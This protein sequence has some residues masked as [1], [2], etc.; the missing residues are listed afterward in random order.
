LAKDDCSAL[1][2]E[3]RHHR[4]H[5]HVRPS[6]AGAEHPESRQKDH[7]VAEHIIAR[8]DP[9][10]AHVGIPAPI[11]PKQSEGGCVGKQRR[12]ADRP[13]RERMR[14][15]AMQRMPDRDGDHPEAKREHGSP[16]GERG[17][18]AVAQRQTDHEQADRIVRGIPEEIER[19]GLQRGRA[20]RKT[21]SDL[22]REHES[23][24]D[25][26]RP[27]DTAIGRVLA[28]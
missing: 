8:A 27:K 16:F 18:S 14:Q 25:Q 20:R 22:D 10:R 26:D 2:S 1:K 3:S 7:E 12:K 9:S 24:H 23:I 13:H 6:G 19:I 28:P 15:R 21:S 4:G 11:G 17:H 5:S